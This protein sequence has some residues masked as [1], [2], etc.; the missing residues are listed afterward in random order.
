MA[1][2]TFVTQRK[3]VRDLIAQLKME[4]CNPVMTP[5]GVN[6][7]HL[8]EE[9]YEKANAKL[10]RSVIGKLMYVTHNRPDISFA[11]SL[12]SRFVTNLSKHHMCVA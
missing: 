8:F 6:D 11:V 3:Y 1:E 12:L 2:G 7:K 4:N 5:M 9:R 10:Y